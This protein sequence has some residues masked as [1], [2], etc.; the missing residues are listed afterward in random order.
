MYAVR[1]PLFLTA[2]KREPFEILEVCST[3]GR[4][5]HAIELERTASYTCYTQ[6]I[7]QPP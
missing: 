3:M 6:P 1:S 5:P 7:N 4:T 2:Y